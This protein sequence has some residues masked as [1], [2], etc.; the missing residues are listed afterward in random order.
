M[1]ASGVRERARVTR[2]RVDARKTRWRNFITRRFS[3]THH[4]LFLPEGD[5]GYRLR[6]PVASG[7]RDAE[8][9][10]CHRTLPANVRKRARAAPFPWEEVVRFL[11]KARSRTHD[12]TISTILP[13]GS[14][15]SPTD[16]FIS[17]SAIV[18]APVLKNCR[19]SSLF[20]IRISCYFCQWKETLANTYWSAIQLAR[21]PKTLGLTTQSLLLLRKPSKN[22]SSRKGC[23]SMI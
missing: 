17:S 10:S 19:I 20:L 5:P 1:S 18:Q 6:S 2:T 4:R 16:L 23:V 15:S 13:R 21:C 22:Y 14:N 12:R 7:N 3:M 9:G 11:V 8:L